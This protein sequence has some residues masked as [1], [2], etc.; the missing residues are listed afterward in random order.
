MTQD[1]PQF[2]AVVSKDAG[3]ATPDR[4]DLEAARTQGMALMGAFRFYRQL[5]QQL[6]S[7]Y[8]VVETR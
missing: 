3:G 7:R 2:M 4:P 1:S 5:M 8:K 6:V